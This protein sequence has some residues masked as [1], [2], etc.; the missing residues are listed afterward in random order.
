[1]NS[2]LRSKLPPRR[3][4]LDRLDAVAHVS[5]NGR[6]RLLALFDE[7]TVPAGSVILEAGDL[8]DHLYL[9][10][11]GTVSTTDDQGVLVLHGP[12]SPL[13]LRLLLDRGRLAHALVTMSTTQL[14]TMRRREFLSACK[15]VSGFAFGLLEA[16]A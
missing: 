12:G 9:V 7:V 15:D 8:V 10:A 4:L 11:E 5:S 1:M 2:A 14:W 3:D 6:N 13:G 16:A